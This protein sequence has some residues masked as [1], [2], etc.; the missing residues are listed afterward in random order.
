MMTKTFCV[1]LSLMFLVFC[2]AC[3]RDL[4]SARMT[5]PEAYTH[6]YEAK[7]KHVLRAIAAVL[8][9]KK[10]GENVAIDAKNHRVDSDYVVDGD[11]RTKTS[12]R[13]KQLNWKE[14]EVRLTVIT[15]KKTDGGREMRR[16]LGKSQYE[17]FFSVIEL[18]IYEEMSNVR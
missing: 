11:W 12:A 13:T 8:K 3:A 18:K 2:A 9:E 5:E 1:C 15:E 17:N 4:V 10:I 14:C 7:E 16:L 6:I